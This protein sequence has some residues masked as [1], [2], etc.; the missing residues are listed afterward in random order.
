G[1]TSEIGDDVM[2]Y[3]GVTLGGRSLQRVKRHPTVGDHV[4]IG[5]GARVLARSRSAKMRPSAQTPSWSRTFP[6][7]PPPSVFRPPFAN[8]PSNPIS[9]PIRRYGSDPAAI[10]RAAELSAELAAT[11]DV[12]PGAALAVTPGAGGGF[13]TLSATRSVVNPPSGRARV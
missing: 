4:T 10:A 13:K 1:E 5:T 12:T 9:S 11:L 8:R 7:A 3:H 2:M 6:P